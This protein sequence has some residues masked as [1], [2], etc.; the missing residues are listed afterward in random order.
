MC[1]CMYIAQLLVGLLCS[2]HELHCVSFE[3]KL[4]FCQ[5]TSSLMM[6]GESL[7]KAVCVCTCVD[8]DV[9]FVAW[10]FGFWILK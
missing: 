10:G 9:C 4:K 1:I 2:S 5:I 7:M 8:V 3:K 6:I